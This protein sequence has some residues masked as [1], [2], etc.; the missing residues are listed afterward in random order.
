MPRDYSKVYS[1]LWNDEKVRDLSVE[2]VMAFLFV[3]THPNMTG[4]GAMRHTHEG[5]V[6]EFGRDSVSLREGFR[7]IVAKGLVEYDEKASII[8]LPNFLKYNKPESPNVVKH[9]VS[10]ADTL[11]ESPLKTLVLQR[12]ER[13]CQTLSKGFREALPKDLAKGI[14]IPEPGTGSQEPE[15]IED[16]NC[17][18]GGCR[19]ER[20]AIYESPE[21]WSDELVEQVRQVGSRNFKGFQVTP[22]DR[23]TLYRIA[24]L[25]VGGVA[26]EAWLAD[27]V[28]A[29]K[30]AIDKDSIQKSHASYL[31]GVLK[32]SCERYNQ[33]TIERLMGPLLL[34]EALKRPPAPAC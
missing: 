6:A 5:L 10:Y 28:A 24:A 19:G 12:F 18:E 31:Y 4:L 8:A 26:S 34:P 32:D 21:Q 25:V 20:P 11:P 27:G 1:R 29:T 7:E 22:K 16:H 14:A 15:P 3:L 2:G 9:L 23:I 13:L 33:T 17:N 30:A